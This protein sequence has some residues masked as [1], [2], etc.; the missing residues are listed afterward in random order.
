MQI[1]WPENIGRTPILI[2]VGVL[3][4]LGLVSVPMCRSWQN[5]RAVA[6]AALL[7][8]SIRAHLNADAPVS[9][10][11]LPAD[12]SPRQPVELDDNAVDWHPS[13]GFKRMGWAPT[14]DGYED[15]RCAYRVKV[16]NDRAS[17]TVMA[18][19]DVDRDGEISKWEADAGTPAHEI[20]E[21]L[22]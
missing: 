15:V 21:G 2:G 18:W 3:L 1:R 22:Y 12:W 16:P 10:G 9:D 13:D 14:R 17:F 5:Q 11:F 7:A 20:T 6:E 19:C 8:D 4:V